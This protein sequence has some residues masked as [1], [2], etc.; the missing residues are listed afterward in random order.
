MAITTYA[1]LQ[2]AIAQWLARAGDTNVTTYAPD[3]ITLAEAEINRVLRVRQMEASADVTISAQTASLPT[4]FMAM[5]RLYLNTSPKTMLTYM[6]PED[7][8]ERYAGS[9][10]GRPVVYTIEG[11]NF[12][13]GPAP[14]ATYT[15]KCLYWQRQD[16]SASAHT[17]F[18]QNP[19][20]YLYGSLLQSEAYQKN[21]ERMATWASFYQ[22]ALEQIRLA[23]AKDRHSG[24]VLQVR[25]YPTAV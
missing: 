2:T 12:V 15:G 22:R 19:D 14:D 17:L 21:D 5:R 7:M 24:S 18:T 4:G 20:L 16:L 8:W 13:F 6:S 11:E 10:T 3:F 25:A 9:D 23:D 1:E